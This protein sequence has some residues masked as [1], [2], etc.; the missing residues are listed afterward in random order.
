MTQTPMMKMLC[1]LKSV[2]SMMEE[3]T[4]GSEA[5]KDKIKAIGEFITIAKNLLKEETELLKGKI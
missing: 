3:L 4:D 1:Y 5:D 2:Q